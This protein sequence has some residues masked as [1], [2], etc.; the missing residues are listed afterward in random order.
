[1]AKVTN[2]LGGIDA[3][4]KIGKRMVFR[5]G[6]VVTRYHVPKNPNTIA[7]QNA[8]QA[9]KDL[10]MSYLTREQADLLYAL[11]THDH[12]DRY[13]QLTASDPYTQYHTDA[14][15]DARYVLVSS[16]MPQRI[17]I[18]FHGLGG[19]GGVPASTTYYLAP[20]ITGLQ[21]SAYSSP[22]PIAGTL[23]GLYVRQA[24][25]QPGSGS[26]TLKVFA[27]ATVAALADTG[28]GVTMAAGVAAQDLTDLTHTYALGAGY[29]VQLRDQN[30]A[31]ATG[32]FLGG[33]SLILESSLLS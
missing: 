5:R 15:G 3:R 9:F 13:P 32:G 30:N 4:G 24:A 8:R 11:I 21:A 33:V 12:D 16:L 19:L 29:Q 25:T 10:V 20:F 14:R 6:G 2:P 31:T 1:M 22:I 18:G 17:A 28:I 7:Q 27:G 26:A 23:K